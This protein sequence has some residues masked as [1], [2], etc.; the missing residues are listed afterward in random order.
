[1]NFVST[2]GRNKKENK[3]E[4]RKNVN[5]Q[6]LSSNIDK[7]SNTLMRKTGELHKEVRKREHENKRLL[8]KLNK[9]EAQV[10]KLR[11]HIKNT[12]PPS[13]QHEMELQEQKAPVIHI[14][15]ETHY[16]S[17][18]HDSSK[19]HHGQMNDVPEATVVVPEKKKNVKRLTD[20]VDKERLKKDNGNGDGSS[21]EEESS[22]GESSSEEEEEEE[23]E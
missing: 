16:H 9:L 4:T 5:K 8:M 23:D 6:E 20:L 7:M 13:M 2:S 15:P 14:N 1:M 21:D 3:R 18:H 11:Q 19:L 22:S 12:S 10:S 17:H